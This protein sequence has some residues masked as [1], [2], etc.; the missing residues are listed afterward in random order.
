MQY[1]SNPK[2]DDVLKDLNF[3]D[4]KADVFVPS[5][6]NHSQFLSGIPFG[7]CLLMFVEWTACWILGMNDFVHLYEIY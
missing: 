3:E 1:K 6:V 4:R 2:A 7:V 5:G